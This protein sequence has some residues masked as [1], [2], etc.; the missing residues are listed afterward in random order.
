MNILTISRQAESEQR[1]VEFNYDIE[2][3]Q[4]YKIN[5]HIPET[6]IQRKVGD[7][8]EIQLV[9]YRDDHFFLVV[10]HS[11]NEVLAN[12]AIFQKYMID[13]DLN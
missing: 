13:K 9:A 12:Q 10:T 7:S 3:A 4:N 1:L 8:L 6:F 5:F 2:E 11:S